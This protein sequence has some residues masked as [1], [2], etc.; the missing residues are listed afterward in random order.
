[1]AFLMLV[2]PLNQKPDAYTKQLH[3]E[4]ENEDAH[5]TV[6]AAASLRGPQ[7]NTVPEH[8]E[9]AQQRWKLQ[10]QQQKTVC[11]QHKMFS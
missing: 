11:D 3:S 1:M 2:D 6:A 5:S 4:K 9:G 10:V 7:D 8:M